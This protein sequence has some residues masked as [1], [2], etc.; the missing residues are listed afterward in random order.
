M[1]HAD[2]GVVSAEHTSAMNCRMGNTRE[3]VRILTGGGIHVVIAHKSMDLR[4]VNNIYDSR[5][6]ESNRRSCAPW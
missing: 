3:L 6:S 1:H 2:T 5:G 4:E